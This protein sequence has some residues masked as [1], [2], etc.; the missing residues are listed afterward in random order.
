MMPYWQS[1]G[2]SHGKAWEKSPA[3][4]EKNGLEP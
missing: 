3:E 2:I 1:L 4:S